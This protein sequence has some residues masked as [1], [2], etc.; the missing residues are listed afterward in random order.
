M[1]KVEIILDELNNNT[2]T[3]ARFISKFTFG[4]F[5]IRD[6]IQEDNNFRAKITCGDVSGNVDIITEFITFS[7]SK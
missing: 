3:S 5:I 2:V 4:N 1:L 6:I 7:I